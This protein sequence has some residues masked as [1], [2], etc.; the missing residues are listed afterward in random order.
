MGKRS[1]QYRKLM[2]QYG[3]H[4]GFREPFQ[5]LV[6]AEILLDAARVDFLALLESTL[7]GKIKPS[8][9]LIPST[10]LR[11]TEEPLVITTCCMRHLYATN[12]QPV[13]TMAKNFERRRC[14]HQDLENPLS[15]SECIIGVLDPKGSSTNKFRYVVATQDANMRAHLRKV[16]GVPL[17]YFKRS[18]MIMEPMA[19]SSKHATALDEREKFRSGLKGKRVSKIMGSRPK[20]EDSARVD[21]LGEAQG[22]DVVREDSE[23]SESDAEEVQVV[24]RKTKGLSG[25]NPLSALK[26][27]KSRSAGSIRERPLGEEMS[28]A[29]KRR[30]RH[31]SKVDQPAR[32]ETDAGPAVA[33]PG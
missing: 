33:M 22:V 14:N 12:N 25:P 32:H 16:K 6:D 15:A 27:K 20:D 1:K 3:I 26:S 7:H 28:N 18:V 17:I 13:I 19:G 23:E 2:Q 4:F 30:R 29:K 9:N 21:N 5:V 11:H 10:L 8:E 24:K 31:R